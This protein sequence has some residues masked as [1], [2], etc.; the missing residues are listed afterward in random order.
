MKTIFTDS[1]TLLIFCLTLLTSWS[2]E[3]VRNQPGHKKSS[4]EQVT[5]NPVTG[6]SVLVSGELNS[7]ANCLT[8]I[9]SG[10][11]HGKF[12]CTY[13][14]GNLKIDGNYLQDEKSGLWTYYYLNGNKRAELIFYHDLLVSDRIDYDSMGNLTYYQ[15]VDNKDSLRYEIN[16][17]DAD[18]SPLSDP[19][20]PLFLVRS[21]PVMYAD[22]PV[23]FACYI[24][25]PPKFS[26]NIKEVTILHEESNTKKNLN[27]ELFEDTTTIVG[28]AYTSN[29]IV[30]EAGAY[31]L[32]YITEL[33]EL[34]S[35]KSRIDTTVYP[36]EVRAN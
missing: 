20:L 4:Y 11:R 18:T 36:L 12:Y 35:G 21:V 24:G 3:P 27:F 19:G 25:H 13:E 16:Y 32:W 6:D 1:L 33:K 34:G 30:V 2:C 7:L 23:S 8:T 31:T 15:F 28:G 10:Q 29:L 9:K 22:N 17:Q 26:F 5:L 14:N